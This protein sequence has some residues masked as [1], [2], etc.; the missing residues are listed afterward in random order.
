MIFLILKI[1]DNTF[2]GT[3]VAGLI[4]ARFGLYLYQ[5]QKTTDIKYEDYRKIRELASLLFANIEIAS[6]NYEGQL[7]I[8]DGKNPDL[9]SLLQA[10]ITDKDEIRKKFSEEFNEIWKKINNATD[11]LVAQLKIDGNYG[12]EI[13]IITEKVSKISFLL[14]SVNVFYL[15]KPEDI[16]EYRKEFNKD[17]QPVKDTLQNII[18]LK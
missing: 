7:N 6:K 13:K 15:S 17:L 2:F 5:K 4:I 14:L 9:K 10:L 12:E 16:E 3:L 1:L 8:Y 18:K 11:N